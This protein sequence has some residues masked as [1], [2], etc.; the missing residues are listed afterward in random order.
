MTYQEY[1]QL[2]SQLPEHLRKEYRFNEPFDYSPYKC[3]H[4]DEYDYY[5]ELDCCIINNV[6]IVWESGNPW[7]TPENPEHLNEFKRRIEIQT[8]D[9]IALIS[10]SRTDKKMECIIHELNNRT[11]KHIKKKGFVSISFEEGN[12][13]YLPEQIDLPNN[14]KM[15]LLAKCLFTAKK[16][17][18]IRLLPKS[19]IPPSEWDDA[20]F[21]I[22]NLI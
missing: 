12:I 8:T 17:N 19:N 4:T 11:T 22:R 15:L 7:V 13:Y 16:Y 3:I 20:I 9:T 2:L 1:T 5:P 6:P 14:N 21:I 10:I 18:T